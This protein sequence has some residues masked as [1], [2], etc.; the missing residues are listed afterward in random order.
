[1]SAIKSVLTNASLFRKVYLITLFLCQI[2]FVQIAT[3]QLAPFLFVWGMAITGYNIVIKGS[4]YRLRHGMWIFGFVAC[5]LGTAVFYIMDNFA[6]NIF[7]AMHVVLCCFVFYGLHTEKPSQHK[8]E[9]YFVCKFIVIATSVAAALGIAFLF[10]GVEYEL[11]WVKIA[12]FEN[13]FTGIYSN[14]NLLG[15]S[16]AVALV[17]CHMCL[18]KDFVKTSGATRLSRIWIFVCAALNAIS[19]FLCDS[20]GALLLVICYMAFSLV[21]LI[22]EQS[23]KVGR[24][25]IFGQ[26]VALALAG[27]FIITAFFFTSYLC[28]TGFSAI[29]AARSSEV[30]TVI[31]SD[32]GEVVAPQVPTFGHEAGQT[33]D[34]GRLD[35]LRNAAQLF[36]LNP[37]FGIGQGN[38][39]DFAQKLL[40]D[41][42][43]ADNIHFN[44]LHNGYMTILV[45]T[46]V[47]GFA[48]F[49][50]FGLRFAKEIF[51]IILK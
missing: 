33:L 43:L 30:G 20:R 46:G 3:F 25:R 16:A 12:I 36:L 31:V 38:I 1:M 22:F 18:K 42:T 11:F 10:L 28:K 13:R 5:G 32:S 41:P 21:F 50:I 29:L 27:A 26:A 44:D 40:S 23:K 51:I 7:M 9:A 39:V 49:S 6:E 47:L 8:G 4:F 14:P 34:N 19:L 2:S 37:F 45:S 15:F 48:V 24:K 35:L 17:C